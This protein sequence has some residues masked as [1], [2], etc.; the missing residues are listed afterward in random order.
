MALLSKLIKAASKFGPKVVKE[1]TKVIPPKVTKAN[2]IIDKL[3]INPL[4]PASNRFVRRNAAKILNTPE[5]KKRLM[6]NIDEFYR[7]KIKTTKEFYNFDTNLNK[8][9]I[10]K[11]KEPLKKG[12]SAATRK[13]LAESRAKMLVEA[14]SKAS[15]HFST[16]KQEL[17]T[18]IKDRRKIN[19]YLDKNYNKIIQE[20]IR[21]TPISQSSL[22]REIL[23]KSK[24]AGMFRSWK[25]KPDIL[26]ERPFMKHTGVHEMVHASQDAIDT[27]ILTKLGGSIPK[28][29]SAAMGHAGGK[30]NPAYAF[31]DKAL[32]GNQIAAMHLNPNNRIGRII[33]IAKEGGEN[34]TNYNDVFDFIKRKSSTTS[35]LKR[36]FPQGKIGKKLSN[37]EKLLKRVRDMHEI[38]RGDALDQKLP[39]YY[40]TRPIEISARLN[41]IRLL[42]KPALNMLKKILSNQRGGAIAE[43]TKEIIE[44][45][46]YLNEVIGNKSWNAL[47]ELLHVMPARQIPKLLDKAWGVAPVLPMMDYLNTDK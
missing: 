47:N 6:D 28:G 24:A 13:E 27:A 43:K 15:K 21:K 29:F 26:L 30:G 17:Q 8:E 40:W 19:Q 42:P 41:E 25:A 31:I 4:T 36:L 10:K 7:Q 38:R 12:G 33:K 35:G 44:N 1:G 37:K 46:R 11:L 34:L 23:D 20:T 45:N 2:K 3:I 39:G 16:A 32:K 22:S 14:E 18:L 9:I 5:A